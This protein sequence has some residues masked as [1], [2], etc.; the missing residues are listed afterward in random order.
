MASA[1]DRLRRPSGVQYD[2]LG[3]WVW[4]FLA[5]P[6]PVPEQLIA[7]APQVI[8]DHMLGTWADTDA[9]PTEIRAA[10]TGQFRDSGRI[11][12]IC[13][14]YRAA[15]TLDYQH[16]QADRGHRR[17]TCPTLV[18]WSHTGPVA[19]WYQPLRIWRTWS[20]VLEY[21]KLRLT[22]EG[23][24]AAMAVLSQR[25]AELASG[26]FLYAF[27][28]V[29]ALRGAHVLAGLDDAAARGVPLP[30]GGLPGVYRDFLRREL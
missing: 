9:F 20:D 15:A 17:I 2:S 23:V 29:E 24:P 30:E 27:Y 11:H 6:E 4:S 28:V 10:Y 1:P 7:A 21:L 13:E 14:Q 22:P 8:V 12:A 5:A 3:F 16:D 19:H 26:N 18:L 25:I